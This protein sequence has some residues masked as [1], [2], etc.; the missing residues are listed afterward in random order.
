MPYIAVLQAKIVIWR[1]KLLVMAEY[2][3]TQ[4]EYLPAMKGGFVFNSPL[5]QKNKQ[6]TYLN[7]VLEDNWL[8]VARIWFKIDGSR[9]V[10]G[11]GATF[12]SVDG[13]DS[14]GIEAG[15]VFLKEVVH[16]LIKKGITELVIRHWPAAY[17]EHNWHKTFLKA[18]FRNAITEINQHLVVSLEGFT[19]NLRY[20]E[21][22][23]LKQAEKRAFSFKILP[24]GNLA[25]V[26][27]LVKETR[28]RKGYPVSMSLHE[29]QRFFETMPENYLLF[30]LF[31]GSKLIAASVSI[32]V[33]DKILYN[34]Y[35]A[36]D[37]AYRP[38]SPLVMLVGKIYQYC[39]EA[40]IE[41]L[42]LGVSSD[43]GEINTGLFDFK[44]N[45]G[46]LPTD[47]NTYIFNYD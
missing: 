19:S 25:M 32:R 36:D 41:I 9:A 4:V 2:K 21:R 14:P 16:L 20:N 38:V 40:G 7:Y 30:G 47:K 29:L 6:G 17:M 33:A 8:P 23:K 10:S 34:F 24:V 44:R 39:Q 5:F 28:V 11:Q 18:G 31:D 3:V 22:K 42:D 15:E 27:E 13:S 12:G 43:K 46:C 37:L 45:L 35:H 1:S 26:Y